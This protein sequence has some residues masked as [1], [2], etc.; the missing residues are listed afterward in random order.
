[1]TRLPIITTAATFHDAANAGAG[2]FV[3]LPYGCRPEY[4]TSEAAWILRNVRH[5]A[6]VG[7]PKDT[8]AWATAVRDEVARQILSSSAP[9]VVCE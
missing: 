5:I 2:H 1:M 6:Y 9:V 3:F 7:R 8:E 4:V